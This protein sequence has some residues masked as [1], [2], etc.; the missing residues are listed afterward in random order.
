MNQNKFSC[1]L[2]LYLTNPVQRW[3]SHIEI[4]CITIF[5]IV[6][7][8]TDNNKEIYP[9]IH[10]NEESKADEGI[11]RSRG[12]RRR[13]GRKLSPPLLP[14]ALSSIAS[15]LND[16]FHAIA[17]AVVRSTR[18]RDF[19][20]LTISRSPSLVLPL[21]RSTIS[22]ENRTTTHHDGETR[23]CYKPH[24]KME[25]F[26]ITKNALLKRSYIFNKRSLNM[27]CGDGHTSYHFYQKDIAT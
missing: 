10:M 11:I 25:N 27:H 8:Q 23:N 1:S 21:S 16:P 6:K 17:M 15:I 3:F 5:E 7:K 13:D 14:P 19:L 22:I 12:R 2:S 9:I 20:K 18:S 24:W 4:V 26:I